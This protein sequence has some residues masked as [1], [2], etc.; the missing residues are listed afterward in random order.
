MSDTLAK[1]GELP[2]PWYRQSAP[3]L[4]MA[5]PAIV[6]VASFVTLW[7]ALRSDD[8]LVSDDYYR[9]GLNINRTLA[10]SERA[11][12]LGLVAAVSVTSESLSVRLSGR[13]PA[14]AA[15]ATLAAT[16]SHPTRAGLDQSLILRRQGD[17]Y[18]GRFRLPA[19]GHWLLQLEDETNGW[20]LVGNLVLPA[21]G[22]TLL[23][24]TDTAAPQK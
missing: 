24:A 10:Q 9:R 6:V 16:L 20:R 15:P 11:A 12:S 8:G 22:E 13:A 18:R 7:L 3:W 1:A 17:A 14:F 4:L 19:A 21:N 23:G 2:L 5:G